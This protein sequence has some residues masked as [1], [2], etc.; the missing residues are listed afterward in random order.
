MSH[1]DDIKPGAKPLPKL[2]DPAICRA[3]RADGPGLV[4]CLVANSR[5][6]EHVGF[7]DNHAFCLSPK[8]EEII[9]RT[10]SRR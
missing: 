8:R 2:P 1:K 9:I 3:V 10:L 7:F 6:C 5:D 4:S